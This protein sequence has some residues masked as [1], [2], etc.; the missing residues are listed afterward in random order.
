MTTEQMRLMTHLDHVGGWIT[1]YELSGAT[2]LAQDDD[3]FVPSVVARG[4][5]DHDPVGAAVRI[6][7]EGRSALEDSVF[8]QRRR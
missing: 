4:W 2:P 3:L 8:P 1:L 6:T 5:A 7:N